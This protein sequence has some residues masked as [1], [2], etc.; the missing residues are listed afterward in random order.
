MAE[1]TVSEVIDGDTFKVKGDWKWNQRRG[2]T[3]RTS[4]STLTVAK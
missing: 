3:V 4:G 2:D 1:F